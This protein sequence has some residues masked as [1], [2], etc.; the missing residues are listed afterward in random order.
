MTVNDTV[1][2]TRHRLLLMTGKDENLFV[3]ILQNVR[4]WIF[5]DLWQGNTF[6]RNVSHKPQDV[7]YSFVGLADDGSMLLLCG[8]YSLECGRIVV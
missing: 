6:L 1:R 4:L 8:F 5:L 7:P 3:F 2:T